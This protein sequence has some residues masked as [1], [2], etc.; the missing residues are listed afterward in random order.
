MLANC[1][2]FTLGTVFAQ[3]FL[4]T[5]ESRTCKG[6]T[7]SNLGE[8]TDTRVTTVKNRGT[9]HLLSTFITLNC[10]ITAS[11]KRFLGKK[12]TKKENQ[13]TRENSYQSLLFLEIHASNLFLIFFFHLP[14]TV[15]K[16]E[17]QAR[18]SC[19]SQQARCTTGWAEMEQAGRR[20]AGGGGGGDT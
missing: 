19:L 3:T 8:L 4:Q 17:G 13:S 6:W 10:S 12:K 1:Q 14:F 20:V 16:K 2:K 9:Q 11:N 5:G 18:T 7:C 15:G